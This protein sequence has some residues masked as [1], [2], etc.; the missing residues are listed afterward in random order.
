MA[1][2]KTDTIDRTERRIPIV[3]EQVD[4]TKR[5]VETGR[6]TVRSVVEEHEE[7]VQASLMQQDVRV[8]RVPFDREIDEAPVVR[9]ENGVTIIPVVDEILVIEKRLVLREEIHVH[10]TQQTV[11]VEKPV[12]MRSTNVTIEKE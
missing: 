3:E 1:H 2:K 9:E 10:K 8:E 7:L 5:A 6:V 11:D 4:I 12:T